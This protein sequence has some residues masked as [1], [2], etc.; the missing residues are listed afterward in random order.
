MKK[1]LAIFLIAIVAC[2]TV[3]DLDLEWPKWLTD[4]WNWISNAAKNAF[5]W[6]K[7]K[8]ILDLVKSWAINYGKKVAIAWCTPY[9]T[10]FVCTAAVEGICAIFGL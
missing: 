4:A 10:P 1:F 5:N 9:L 2:E 3:E 8:G 6:L 7:D